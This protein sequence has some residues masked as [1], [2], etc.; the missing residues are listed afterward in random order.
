MDELWRVYNRIYMVI[1]PM[2]RRD[3]VERLIGAD[4]D[5]AAMYERALQHAYAEAANPPESCI[6]YADCEDWVTFSWFNVGSN[7]N[8]LGRHDEAAAAYDQTRNLGLYYRMLWYQFGPYEAYYAVGRHDD[9]I[10]LA[11]ATLV[12]AGNLEESYYWRGMSR[13]ATGDVSGARTDFET[14]LRYHRDWPPAVAALESL[15]ED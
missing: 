14:A 11:N 1:Y 2:D 13:L 5:D 9:V 4:M 6:A 15:S 3:D 8:A 10:S 7:L 12:T